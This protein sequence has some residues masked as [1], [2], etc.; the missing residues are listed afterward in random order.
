[1]TAK[2]AFVASGGVVLLLVLLDLLSK[3]LIEQGGFAFLVALVNS[4]ASET[5][6]RRKKGYQ[7]LRLKPF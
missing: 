5:A 3:L 1:M 4:G 7:N 6:Q 2:F